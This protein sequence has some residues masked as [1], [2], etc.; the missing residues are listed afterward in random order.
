MP[1]DAAAGRGMN[2]LYHADRIIVSGDDLERH[3]HGRRRDR[4]DD[5]LRFGLSLQTSVY[6][7]GRV[8]SQTSMTC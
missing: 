5:S 3:D 2:N 4:V 1:L 7:Y 6:E 8:L